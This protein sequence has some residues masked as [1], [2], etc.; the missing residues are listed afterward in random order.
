MRKRIVACVII[1]FCTTCLLCGCFS[2]YQTTYD[3]E[4]ANDIISQAVY[5]SL[6]GDDLFYQHTK[7]TSDI[8]YYYYII[9]KEEPQVIYDLVLEINEVIEQENINSKICLQCGTQVPGG[10][11]ADLAFTN[12]SDDTLEKP[13]YQVLKKLIA[14]YPDVSGSTLFTDP[15]IY[16]VLDDIRYLEIDEQLQ[17]KAEEEGIDWYEYWPNLEKIDI[18]AKE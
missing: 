16:T 18:I 4:K 17:Q 11:V 14:R 9:A 12:Y 1:F 13:D 15:K 7:E 10:L 2:L 6:G 5:E 3:N 8:C